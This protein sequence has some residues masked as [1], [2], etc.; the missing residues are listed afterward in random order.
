MSVRESLATI[1]RVSRVIERE[2]SQCEV[3]WDHVDDKGVYSALLHQHQHWWEGRQGSLHGGSINLT[4]AGGSKNIVRGVLQSLLGIFNPRHRSNGNGA[5]TTTT[6]LSL[7]DSLIQAEK[8]T[9]HER[10]AGSHAGRRE[11]DRRSST[12]SG[13]GVG[14]ASEGYGSFVVVVCVAV[15]VSALAWLWLRDSQRKKKK[16]M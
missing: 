11:G 12:T 9:Q 4:P 1:A 14:T 10:S 8:Q 3:H 13:S 6:P 15:L 7:H 16:M 5:H 2:L